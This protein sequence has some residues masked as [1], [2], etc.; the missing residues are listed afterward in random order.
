M[1]SVI[2]A[3]VFCELTLLT[4]NFNKIARALELKLAKTKYSIFST[5]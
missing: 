5:A 4:I 3:S 1:C 2:T